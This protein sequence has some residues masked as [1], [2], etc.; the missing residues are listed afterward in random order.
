MR[1][2][3]TGGSGFLG[4]RLVDML[5]A[6]GAEVAILARAGSQLP[7]RPGVRTV[8]AALLP[9]QDK[10]DALAPVQ[11]ALG[12]ATHVFHCAGCSTDWARPEQ[13]REGNVDHLRALLDLAQRH[14]RR[15]ERFV[16]VSTTDVYG[17]PVFAGDE[18][19]PRRSVGLPY[20]TTKCDG[21]G[22]VWAAAGR[23]LPVTVLRP[24]SI[25]GPGGKAFVNDIAAL[26]R[27]RQMLLVDGGR[28]R[29]GFV[30]VDDVCR[31]ALRAAVEP[32]ARGEAFNLSSVDGVTWRAYTAALA[33]ALGVAEPWL[34]LPFPAAMALAR[35]SE[36]PH[37]AGL[38]GRPLL[39]RHAVYL[40]GRDQQYA[41]A[42]AREQL[43]WSP[44]VGLEEGM[45]R[46]AAP[47]LAA[48]TP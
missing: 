37:R 33:R 1:A 32:R 14:G 26:L 18:Y 21:E 4:G 35:A 17:Y 7:H 47:L 34:K 9:G 38:P 19:T 46:S 2:L 11:D 29:G 6:Q 30:Y 43:N 5:L 8:R 36:L 39:T 3:V 20:N 27:R 12:A 16:H 24:A 48:P 25:Y 28:V 41:T 10:P 22:L 15:L 23:G 40:L 45:E 42:K 31:A 44:R 13:F